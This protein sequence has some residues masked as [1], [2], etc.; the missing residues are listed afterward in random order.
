MCAHSAQ[1]RGTGGGA[2]WRVPRG[3][4]PRPASE[5]ERRGLPLINGGKISPNRPVDVEQN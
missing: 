5:N 2:P 4:T 1:N 3:G